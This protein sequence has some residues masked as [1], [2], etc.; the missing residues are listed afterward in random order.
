MMII[1]KQDM[2]S[3]RRP[4]NNKLGWMANADEALMMDFA[5]LSAT[6]IYIL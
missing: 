3:R 4:N 5:Q 6:R 1:R 2:A